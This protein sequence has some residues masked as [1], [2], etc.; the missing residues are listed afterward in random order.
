M[1]P[2]PAPRSSGFTTTTPMPLY[3]TRYGEPAA[4]KLLVLH[5]GP[6]AHH[7]YLLP[8]LLELSSDYE[9]V[10][11]DQRGGGQSKT[12]DR[13]PITWQTHVAD[14]DL[15]I[16]ELTLDP[17]SIVGYSWG[18][19]LAMLYSIEAF[20]GRARHKPKR[21]V[22]IDPA[23]VNR[24]YRRAFESEF[25]R[26]QSDPAVAG[27]RAELATSGL[28][29]RDPEA[30]RQRT[31]E[32]SVAGY[33][34]NP[35]AAHDLTPFRVTGRVQQSVWDS[36][37]E[38][39]LLT[40]GKLDSVRVPTLILHGDR[41]PIPIASSEAAA[42]TMGARFVTID[43]AGHVPYVENPAALFAAIREFLSATA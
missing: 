23:P 11:Y 10:F 29:E 18:G 39:D 5:G 36:L 6:G 13:T 7:D 35:A 37:G 24:E 32:L 34:A 30:Y 42:R 1:P 22:L 12:D 2:I 38:F 17:L 33:F 19:L 15:V 27:L 41:D 21:L 14:L 31:F 26:R 16:D 9:L 3:W 4:P 20:A 28:R 8:Q 25:A 43:N 40:A